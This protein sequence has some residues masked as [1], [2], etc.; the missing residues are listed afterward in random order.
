MPVLGSSA[1]LVAAS[2]LPQWISWLQM[3]FVSIDFILQR[4]A[5][6]LVLRLL[7]DA[8]ITQYLLPEL[9]KLRRATMDIPVSCRRI[10][11]PSV[12]SFGKMVIQQ[13][14]LGRITIRRHGN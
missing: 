5:A 13:H 2:L 1:L 11:V 8:I 12:K 4:Y 14:G 7:Q 3:A 10:A 6:Q 9:Q